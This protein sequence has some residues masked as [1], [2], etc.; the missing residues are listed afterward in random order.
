MPEVTI[1]PGYLVSTI[2]NFP[3]VDLFDV[4]IKSVSIPE[5]NGKKKKICSL[6]LH[7]ENEDNL[8][9]FRE[10]E[11]RLLEHV[12]KASIR[13]KAIRISPE[14]IQTYFKSSVTYTDGI[15]FP[16]L[17]IKTDAV[18]YKTG[19]TLEHMKISPK[20]M[21]IMD[22]DRNLNELGSLGITWYMCSD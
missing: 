17:R 20:Y 1:T 21:Y 15:N 2:E 3:S 4:V 19:Q 6:S 8:N 14:Y 5:T 12:K 11:A 16:M 18:T 10:A 7:M 9:S 22:N 13:F